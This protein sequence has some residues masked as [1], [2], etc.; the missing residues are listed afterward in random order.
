M[1]QPSGIFVLLVVVLAATIP[2]VALG[3]SV[4]VEHKEDDQGWSTPG[5]E[6]VRS[7]IRAC[8]RQK[9]TYFPNTRAL[10]GLGETWA[11]IG[12]ARIVF[13]LY[14]LRS[15]RPL[16]LVILLVRSGTVVGIIRTVNT[17]VLMLVLLILFVLLYC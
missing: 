6:Q 13:E 16:K 14:H 12:L 11:T 7:L 5:D 3:V 17:D 10:C 8:P 1:V 2:A 15:S 4:S 9:L